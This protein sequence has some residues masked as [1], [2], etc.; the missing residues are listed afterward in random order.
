MACLKSLS[1]LHLMNFLCIK[2][3]NMHIQKKN[4]EKRNRE[5]SQPIV[6]HSLFPKECQLFVEKAVHMLSTKNS[7]ILQCVFLVTI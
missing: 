5:T 1:I 4:G 3:Y 7:V 2:S 6:G